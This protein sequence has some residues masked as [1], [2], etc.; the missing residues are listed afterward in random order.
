MWLAVTAGDTGRGQCLS[1]PGLPRTLLPTSSR[2]QLPWT[3]VLSWN[4]GTW[5]RPPRPFSAGLKADHTRG[6]PDG[7]GGHW[8]LSLC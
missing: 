8:C 5:G 2:C 7:W 1:P 4:A 6:P 3:H